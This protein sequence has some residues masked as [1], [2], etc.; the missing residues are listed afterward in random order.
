MNTKLFRVTSTVPESHGHKDV[1]IGWFVLQR[2]APTNR[3]YR[4]LIEG[5]PVGDANTR[6]WVFSAIDELFSEDEAVAWAA[7]LRKTALPNMRS[8]RR[9]CR[10]CQT[11]CQ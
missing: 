7:W 1:H 10:I 4:E 5:E 2:P 8:R 11:P 6:N 9:S 3:P